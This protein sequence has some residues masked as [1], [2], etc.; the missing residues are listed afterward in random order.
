MREF[1]LLNKERLYNQEKKVKE[2]LLKTRNFT[3]FIVFKIS[4]P[5]AIQVI[6]ILNHFLLD[7]NIQKLT[8]HKVKFISTHLE[9]DGQKTI[10]P[11]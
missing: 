10:L 8:V 1:E 11:S 4:Y 6:I 3:T 2:L 9:F 7:F 5:A